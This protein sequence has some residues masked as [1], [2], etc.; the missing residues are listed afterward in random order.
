MTHP[1]ITAHKKYYER[2]RTHCRAMIELVYPF[3]KDYTLANERL[4]NTL[5]QIIAIL[6]SLCLHLKTERQKVEGACEY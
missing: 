3:Q 5:S 4:V 1:A 2:V 6:S